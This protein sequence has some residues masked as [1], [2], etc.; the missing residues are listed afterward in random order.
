MAYT[1]SGDSFV[2]A[3]TIFLSTIV[4]T[5]H[6]KNIIE[7]VKQFPTM[8]SISETSNH[9]LQKQTTAHLGQLSDRAFQSISVSLDTPRLDILQEIKN[10]Y[11]PVFFLMKLC[12]PVSYT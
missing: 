12:L 8:L 5:L 3:T 6:C 4:G 10:I 2:S 1:G 7:I 9:L 11:L